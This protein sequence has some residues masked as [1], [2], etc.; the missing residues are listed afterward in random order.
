[1]R[2]ESP[3]TKDACGVVANT[4]EADVSIDLEVETGVVEITVQCA[5]LSVVKV[6]DDAT[7]DAG[8]DIGYT[9]AVTNGG[10]GVAR[11]VVLT[12]V[13]PADDGLAWEI[14]GGTGATECAI[15]DGVLTC[16]FG[17]LRSG[18]EV[19]VHLSSPTTAETCGTVRNS[20]AVTSSNDGDPEAGPVDIVVNCPNIAIE[21]TADA[22]VVAAADQVGF[23]ITVTNAGPG[24]ARDVVVT[25]TLPT[26]AGLGWSI[27]GGSGAERCEIVEGVL[28]CT[29]GDMGAGA[30]ATVHISSDTDATTCGLID[31]TAVVTIANG[32]GDQDDA[33]VSVECPELGI[34][35]QKDGPDL[36]HVGDTVTYT[37]EVTSTT[38]EPLYDVVVGDANCDAGAPAYV[39]GDDEDFVLEPGE[40]WTYT[41]DHVVT[42]EDADPLPN[43]A[44]VTGT[45]DDGR[46]VS[47]QD[48]HLIDLIHPDI[49]IVKSVTPD[50]GEPGDIVTYRYEVTNT[51][52]TTLY[53][54]RVDD[55]VIGHIGDIEVLEPG[56]TV[57]LT[58][59]WELPSE[60]IDVIN[61]GTAT[62]TDV[63]GEEVSDDD[64][65][66]VTVVLPATPP[67]TAFTGGDTWRLG[68]LA[69]MLLLVGLTAVGLGRRRR[70][71]TV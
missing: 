15:E 27:D 21:K 64:D 28:T 2:L 62:G 39:A 65:A 38:D 33:Q 53:D 9:I 3:T 44:T 32:D 57:T 25:D 71:R 37:F 4:A 51:G 1:V 50:G 59:D 69:G 45:S 46:D 13:L 55:D 58:K 42:D 11:D 43:T 52:D 67:P 31:N 20:V 70:P 23:T 34:D 35:I 18:A 16:S 8:D 47:D 24:I 63:L 56:E 68:T 5:A 40:V 10:A 14:D 30:T 41:C 26:N 66:F 61:I 19:T 29:F 60:G 6:A 48:D 12:D 17:D 22:E 49:R 36:A 7:V 54:V